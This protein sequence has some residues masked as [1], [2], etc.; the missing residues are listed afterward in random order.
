MELM[1]NALGLGTYF[2]GFLL[3]AAQTNPKIA[4]FLGVP[5]GKNLVTCMVIGY[6]NIKYFRTTPR[7]DADILFL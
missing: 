7:K 6:P 5:E 1:V 4:E 3:K 2:S